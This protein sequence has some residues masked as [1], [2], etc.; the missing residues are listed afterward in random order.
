MLYG[1]MNQSSC[2]NRYCRLSRN[3]SSEPQTRLSIGEQHQLF[4][5]EDMTP[6]KQF[7]APL[8]TE[9]LSLAALTLVPAVSSDLI[10]PN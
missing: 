6:R 8:L 3:R 10:G 4:F 2:R 9:Q 7:V 5:G 1:F